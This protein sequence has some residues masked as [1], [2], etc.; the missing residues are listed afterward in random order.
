M[1]PGM[2]DSPAPKILYIEDDAG[3]AAL[4]QRRLAR[5][6]V[7]V[8][9]ARS[10]EEGLERLRSSGYDLVLVDYRLPG[11]D[12]LEVIRRLRTHDTAPPVIVVSA[13]GDLSVAVESMRLGAVDYLLK[14]V[15]SGFL[16]V[17]EPRIRRA[18]EVERLAR[19]KEAAEAGSRN[20]LSQQAAILENIPDLAWLKDRDGRFIAVNEPFAT[21]SGTSRDA[22]IGKTDFE[23]W[24]PA[25]ARRYRDDDKA[26]MQSGQRKVVEEPLREA[27]GEQR[28]IETIKT[29]I[30]D[31]NG[32]TVGTAGI[33]R[34][35]TER[36]RAEDLLFDEKERLQV[37]L[38][39]IGDA[40][41]STDAGG[42]VEFLNPVAEHLTGWT[43]AEAS[44]LALSRVF[45]IVNEETR[46]PAPD[47]VA[48][49]LAEGRVIG[50]AN[51]TVLISRTGAEYA[52]QDSAAP[53]R[54]RDG[55]TLLGVVLVFHDVTEARRLAI[56]MT[57]QA[58]HDSLT[59][60]V[61]RR[62]F[63][64]RL[65]RV[66]NSAASHDQEH[67]LCYLDLDQFKVVNDT[68][69]H[70]A[71]DEMLK[72]VAQILNGNVRS[73]D[74]LAR[75]GGDE[76]S[77]ILESCPLGKATE[78]CESMISALQDFTFAWGERRFRVGVSVGIVAITAATDDATQAMSQADVACYTAKER[79]GNRVYVYRGSGG[80][81]T[82]RHLELHRAA[83]L[84]E[85]L[86]KGDFLLFRQPIYPVAVPL[87]QPV[88]YE[89]L[90]RMK[91]RD[92]NLLL[93]ETFVAAA[94]RFGL[95]RDIDQWVIAAA[96]RWYCEALRET[97]EV[98]IAL[99]LSGTSL[100]DTGLFHFIKRKLGEFA[101]PA[102]RVCFEITETA[103]I[104]NFAKAVEFI[105]EL[106][107]EGCRFALDDFGSG[108][109]SFAYL[110][111]IPIDYL[112]IDGGLVKDIA[113]DALD[114]AMVA[115]IDQIGK[116]MGVYTIAECVESEAVIEVLRDIGVDY[117]QGN[118]LGSANPLD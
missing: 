61:N 25:L 116:T 52:I 94:E 63:E 86:S 85:A 105:T 113:A 77:L 89:I 60:L 51:H 14:D 68:A 46:A 36:K 65:Q 37:T 114:R 96:F 4:V 98:R 55:H 54:S 73:R 27:S 31:E 17:M 81:L 22:L 78:I 99:N 107:Q 40:V 90:V 39:S 104:N 43:V 101:I 5:A 11:M 28:W 47:P 30:V 71:G 2:S 75:I 88:E 53:I 6:S 19:A 118:L 111:R 64:G 84:R 10:G 24:P 7:Q 15:G 83:E 69:G 57:H 9:R 115:A 8:E 80:K 92:G 32:E 93:P 42:R 18:L 59:G 117:M 103:A 41:I 72:Q 35:I 13:V 33:A 95:M 97:P 79:G 34:D 56:Q 112:K 87:E 38:Q 67:A 3:L 66:V 49:C 21:S 109:S 62:E 110:K 23:I 26:V 16:D 44:G 82:P 91:Q 20:L 74:T 100:T 108:L 48:R 76:F 45:Q 50:L 106:K 70:V 58:S 12:G 29:P 102:E 1:G